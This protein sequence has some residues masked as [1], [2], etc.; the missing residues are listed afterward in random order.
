MGPGRPNRRNRLQ[1]NLYTGSDVE[2]KQ[3]ISK[4]SSKPTNEIREAGENIEEIDVPAVADELLEGR[5]L[6]G[7][8]KVLHVSSIIG[9]SVTG[10]VWFTFRGYG[11]DRLI[12]VFFALFFILLLVSAVVNRR[13]GGADTI[14]T[15]PSLRQADSDK[16]NNFDNL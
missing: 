15:M 14:S 8:A 16:S 1:A 7:F 4:T 5:R 12:A 2:V 6:R 3:M 10:V 13:I 11:V 9:L